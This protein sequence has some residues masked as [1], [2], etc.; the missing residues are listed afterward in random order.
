MALGTPN[1]KDLLAAAY[2]YRS[3]SLLRKAAEI[4]ENTSD[5]S[6]YG[7][8]QSRIKKAFNEEFVTPEGNL[9]SSKQTAYVVALSLGLIPGDLEEAAA[10]RLAEIVNEYNHLTTGFL[11]TPDLLHVLVNLGIW[12]RRTN[13]CT[14][15][16]TRHG[17][18]W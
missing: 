4:L 9:S 10:E 15:R 8:L 5:V 16:N 2:F 14:D 17:Y 18:I 13:L 7:E 6:F 3:T 1:D 11:G 12:R